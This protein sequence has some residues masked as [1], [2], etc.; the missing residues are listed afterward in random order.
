MENNNVKDFDPLTLPTLTEE[1]LAD[2]LKDHVDDMDKMTDT[3]KIVDLIYNKAVLENTLLPA[4]G[5]VPNIVSSKRLINNDEELDE[6]RNANADTLSSILNQSCLGATGIF[7]KLLHSGFSVR[8]KPFT[9]ADK[10]DLE[11]RISSSIIKLDRNIAGHMYTAMH[12]KIIDIILDVFLSMIDYTTI[13]VA[14]SK[15]LKFIKTKD[16]NLILIGIIGAMYPN[17]YNYAYVCGEKIAVN[18]GTTVCGN[19]YT[20]ATDDRVKIDITELL[21]LRDD[22]SESEKIQLSKT[23]KNEISEADVIKY[24][25]NFKYNKVDTISFSE[26]NLKFTLDSGNLKD[27]L[28]VSNKWIEEFI[29]GPDSFIKDDAESI[30]KLLSVSSIGEYLYCISKIENS[31]HEA[32]RASITSDNVKILSSNTKLAELFNIASVSHINNSIYT[33]GV[34]KYICPS[35]LARHKKDGTTPSEELLTNVNILNV[36]WYLV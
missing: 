14:N 26:F 7:I 24:Q 35:C 22:L 16:L 32:G 20:N 8:L 5:I 9:G 31:T 1:Q 21:Y 23:K 34:P 33:I 29:I 17:G 4:G 25:E 30:I 18:E 6:K 11:Y 10:V 13:N 15:L 19:V 28:Q 36:F 3:I 12:V 2:F 27:Y